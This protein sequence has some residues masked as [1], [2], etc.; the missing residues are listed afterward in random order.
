M[1]AIKALINDANVM[2]TSTN[3]KSN[4]VIKLDSECKK[5][6][7]TINGKLQLCIKMF[8]T[9]IN[10]ICV[11][12]TNA[13]PNDPTMS[14]Y[15]QVV[16]DIV[17]NSPLEPISLFILYIYKDPVYRK[18]IADGNDAFF[19]NENHQ[20]MTKGDSNKV[21]TM[22]QFKSS[23]KNFN[24]EQ[25]DYIKNATRMLLQIAETYIIEKDN[26]NKIAEVMLKLSKINTNI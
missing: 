5:H 23:W 25:K 3:V 16:R 2:S 7:T 9:V 12:V 19:I 4:D 1:Q 20:N 18:N 17:E 26:G 15:N 6:L 22:F 14:T 10:D 11:S 24:N 21:A 13:L 8:N